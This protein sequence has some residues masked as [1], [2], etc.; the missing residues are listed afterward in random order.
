MPEHTELENTLYA[1][2]KY[3]LDRQQTDAD[4]GYLCGPLTE[5]YERLVKAEA[6]F[7]NVPEADVHN[8]RSKNLATREP[9]DRGARAEGLKDLEEAAR[10]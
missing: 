6:A 5:T 3:A 8:R 10:V 4:F 9:A 1:A 2:V 7:L